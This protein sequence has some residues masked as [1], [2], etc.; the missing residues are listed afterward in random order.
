MIHVEIEE[1]YA[2]CSDVILPFIKKYCKTGYYVS[3]AF[4]ASYYYVIV[5]PKDNKPFYVY[6]VRL[7]TKPIYFRPN[8]KEIDEIIDIL[9][10]ASSEDLEHAFDH[11]VHP[12][13][14]YGPVEISEITPLPEGMVSAMN[15][16]VNGVETDEPIKDYIDLRG[17]PNVTVYPTAKPTEFKTVTVT[18]LDHENIKEKIVIAP[19]FN[20][21]YYKQT[22]CAEAHNVGTYKK[23]MDYLQFYLR[24]K[25]SRPVKLV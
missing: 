24:Y 14:K 21:F 15:T 1:D 23:T 3:I 2:V 13:R 8:G 12:S 6:G 4:T 19:P 17:K 18:L 20:T 16:A 11:Y 9:K 10:E 7:N 5:K 22:A 25:V